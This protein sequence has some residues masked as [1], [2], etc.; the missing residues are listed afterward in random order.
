MCSQVAWYAF[1]YSWGWGAMEVSGMYFDRR[2][3]EPN[4]LA[5]YLNILSTECLSFGS[6]HQRRRTVEFLWAKR[7]ELAYRVWYRLFRRKAPNVT[8]AG[9]HQASIEAN[10][11]A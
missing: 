4:R 8:V 7:R 2:F 10:R 1:A 5:F 11:A 9:Q 6:T 3:K